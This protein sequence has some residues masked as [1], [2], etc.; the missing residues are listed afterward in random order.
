MIK[1]NCVIVNTKVI[2]KIPNTLKFTQR[3][4]D[5]VLQIISFKIASAIKKPIHLLVKIA[6]PSSCN[7]KLAPRSDF[8]RGFLRNYYR[9]KL[10]SIFEMLNKLEFGELQLMVVN[11]EGTLNG[12]DTDIIKTAC[13]FIDKPI[14]LCGGANSIENIGMGFNNGASAIGVGRMFTFHGPFKAVLIDYPKRNSIR[15]IL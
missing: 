2:G 12:L 11:R 6:Q 10:E 7:F 4:V 5:C 14:I 9:Y 1:E 3:S 15:K 8:K 13:R